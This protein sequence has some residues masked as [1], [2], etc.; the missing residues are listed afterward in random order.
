MVSS[1]NGEFLVEIQEEL[2]QGGV[3]NG[4]GT[5]DHDS[6]NMQTSQKGLV[7]EKKDKNKF[8]SMFK[9]KAGF[10]K[11]RSLSKLPSTKFRQIAEGRDEMSRSVSST[12]QHPRHHFHLPFVRKI[13][14]PFLMEL[15]KQ[16]IRNPM[17]MALFVWILCVAVSGAILFMVMTGMLNAALPKKSQRDSWFEVN[18]Q[19]LNAL[20]TLMCLYQHP[21]R[22]YHLVLLCR[23]RQKD[24]LKL[25]NIYCKHGTY[26]PHEWM[27]MMVVVL[28]LQLNCFAQYA[29]CG[30][31][32]GYPREKRPA[33]GVGICISAA[34]GAAAAASVYNILSPLGR[35]YET[36]IDQEASVQATA[37]GISQPGSLRLKSLEK[38]Y[39]FAVRE[40]SRVP[41]NKPVWIGGLTDF[42][43]DISLA[44]LSLFCSCCVFGWNMERLGFGNM[45]VHT[46]TFLLFC[47]A[48]FFIFNLAA[49]NINNDA[50]REALGISG[51]VLCIFGLLY[52]GFWRI[53]MRK[54]FN[55]PAYT[56]CCNNPSVTDCFM[57]LCCCSCSL[58]QEVRTADSY[59][60]VEDKFFMK[61]TDPDGQVTLS[62][63]P[64]EDG[65]PLFTSNP[66]SPYRSTSSP[67]IFILSSLSPSRLSGA[68]TPDRQ[69]PTV[70]EDSPTA[71]ANTMKP[72]THPKIHRGDN[73]AA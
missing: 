24:I 57:W 56:S 68:Y 49:V 13:N 41:E 22:F 51:I 64:R 55:L 21:Q 15:C 54:R 8:F 27:H 6:L 7:G 25:R 29:L 39:S 30:L 71:K 2:G 50:V 12:E 28:L 59:E 72:P 18:N 63:L 3:T 10:E 60:I 17:N 32:L 67:P 1:D 65:L 62:P 26:K 36:G 43:D 69:L 23:W 58:A 33:I 11:V 47:A 45:Y 35:E 14:W 16:W 73:P 5:E 40:D 9:N 42:W 70:D 19:I 66:G 20:F 48:P 34:F 46:V 37:A 4:N 53:R 61:Q 52:G 44:Y 38:K 31:N